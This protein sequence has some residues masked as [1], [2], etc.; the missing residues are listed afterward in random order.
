MSCNSFSAGNNAPVAFSL[1]SVTIPGCAP[2]AQVQAMAQ[3][4]INALTGQLPGNYGTFSIGSNEPTPEN[5]DKLWYRVN[6]DC[7]PVGWYIWNGA[8]WGRALPNGVA[9][10][11]IVSYYSTGLNATDHAINAAKISYLDVDPYEATYPGATPTTLYTDPFW[12][13]CDG[14]HGTPDLLGRV[15]VGAGA[16]GGLTNRLMSS[17]GGEES[18]VLTVP[19]LAAHT[20][21]GNNSTVFQG[22]TASGPAAG[23]GY[24][25]T[26]PVV[27]GSTGGNQGHNTMQ[28]FGCY[29]HII[30]TA[31]TF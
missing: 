28:P 23:I 29:Y 8:R 12:R 10:G 13:L 1:G 17:T 5:R 24:L 26:P 4:I 16:G 15:I 7:T 11:V 14:T 20:H 19:E 18:H 22:F 30:R 27:T 31:R 21:D 3:A 2:S 6:S 9:P 25:N